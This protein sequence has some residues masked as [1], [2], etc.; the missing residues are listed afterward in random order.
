MKNLNHA[1]L[2]SC[3]IMLFLLIPEI[4]FSQK[5]YAIDLEPSQYYLEGRGFY[6]ADVL[7][8]RINKQS[9]GIVPALKGNKA[10][11]LILN[12]LFEDELQ[13]FFNVAIPPDSNLA[14]VIVQ[15]NKLWISEIRKEEVDKTVC[16]IEMEFLTPNHQSLYTTNVSKEYIVFDPSVVHAENVA[17]TLIEAVKDFNGKEWFEKYLAAIDTKLPVYIEPK[18]VDSLIRNSKSSSNTLLRIG[19]KGG[20]SYRTASIPEGYDKP[21]E[22]YFQKLKSGWHIGGNLT[23]FWNQGNGAGLIFSNFMSSQTLKDVMFYSPSGNFVGIGDI[24]DDMKFFFIGPAYSFQRDITSTIVIHGDASLGYMSYRN[25]A[26]VGND[27]FVIT[28]NTLGTDI[29]FGMD[30]YVGGN[31][32]VGFELSAIIGSLSK[33]DVNGQSVSLEEYDDLTHFNLSVLLHLYK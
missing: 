28:G 18:R 33:I 16:E 30:F 7:D 25:D 17:A 26:I 9:I 10:S 32:A 8:S 13:S 27:S 6:V 22:D 12:T 2:P 29:A 24:S 5:Y 23:F 14:P 11:L 15:I 4:S 1:F 3:L 20:W 21:I 19:I 31:I